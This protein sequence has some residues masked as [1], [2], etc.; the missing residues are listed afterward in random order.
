MQVFETRTTTGGV[1]FVCQASGVCQTFIPSIS[2][3]E[4]IL[5]NANAVVRRQVKRENAHFRLPSASQKR[6]CLSS[7]VFNFCLKKLLIRRTVH[8]IFL[9]KMKCCHER[10]TKKICEP[11]KYATKKNS[12]S[13]QGFEPMISHR[14]FGRYRILGFHVT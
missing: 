2:N 11:H 13:P 3:E 5:G 1:H 4:K 10:G 7:L 12:E 14:P 9:V 8:L 6:A